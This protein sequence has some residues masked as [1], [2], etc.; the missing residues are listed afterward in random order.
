M[1][2]P[3]H[4]RKLRPPDSDDIITAPVTDLA[5][6]RIRRHEILRGLTKGIVMPGNGVTTVIRFPRECDP[7][8]VT[9]LIKRTDK[10]V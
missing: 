5:M 4:T 6:A 10:R 9:R 7:P 3:G 2:A 1:A 8:G